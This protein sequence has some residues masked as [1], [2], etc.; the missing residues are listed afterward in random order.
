MM[1]IVA[2]TLTK[3]DAELDARCLLGRGLFTLAVGLALD[4]V[5]EWEVRRGATG[6]TAAR[7]AS[8][9]ETGLSPILRWGSGKYGK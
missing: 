2:R 3:R 9:L 4:S 6:L 1:D 8:V 7:V 5:Q